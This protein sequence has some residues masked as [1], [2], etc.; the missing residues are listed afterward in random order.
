MKKYKD[1]ELVK[2]RKIP[3]PVIPAK[4]GIQPVCACPHAD[5]SFQVVAPPQRG[6]PVFTGVGNGT[7]MKICVS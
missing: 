1:D 6:T 7:S 3:F 2:S 4:A 5:R